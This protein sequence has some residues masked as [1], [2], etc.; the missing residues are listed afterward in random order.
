MHGQLVSHNSHDL[1]PIYQIENPRQAN[2]AGLSFEIFDPLSNQ[3]RFDGGS[4]FFIRINL[5]S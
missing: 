5:H 2:R 1:R 3:A 4:I